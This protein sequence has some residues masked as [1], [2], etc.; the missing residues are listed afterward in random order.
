MIDT[1]LDATN[2]T[3]FHAITSTSHGY[4][5]Y[6]YTVDKTNATVSITCENHVSRLTYASEIKLQEN[7]TNITVTADS[8]EDSAVR[9]NED[10]VFQIFITEG[11]HAVVNVD[12]GDT[13]SETITTHDTLLSYESAIEIHHTYTESMAA[14]VKI[15]LRNY[16]FNVTTFLPYALLV[17]NLV[18]GLTIEC[19]AEVMIGES[20]EGTISI[21]VKPDVSLP[22]PTNVSCD[23][24][25]G[26]GN[27]VTE[28]STELSTRQDYV[29]PLTFVRDNVGLGNDVSVSC[30][31]LVSSQEL[32]ASIDVYEEVIG[33]NFVQ[34]PLYA[35]VNQPMSMQIFLQ[36]GSHVSYV[37]ALGNGESVTLT[38]NNTF[39]TDHPFV[40]FLTYDGIGNFTPIVEAR[41]EMSS[42]SGII[43]DHVTVQ[44]DIAHLNISVGS[45]YIW[46]PGSAE[47]IIT[48]SAA[49][50]EIHN[51]HCHLVY[52]NNKTSEHSSYQYIDSME[53]SDMFSFTYNMS[54]PLLGN[55]TVNATCGNMVSNITIQATTRVVLDAVILERLIT[56]DTVLW[57]NTTLMI[58]DIKRF[59][60]NACFQFDMGDGREHI[61]YGSSDFCESPAVDASESYQHIEPN[62]MQPYHEY[63][64]KRFGKYNVTVFA[65]NHVSTDTLTTEAEVL[66]WPCIPP[67]ISFPGNF[68]ELDN[69]MI[70]NKSV[71]FTINP[72]VVIDCMKTAKFTNL[73][74]LYVTGA[75]TPMVISGSDVRWVYRPEPYQQ[76]SRLLPYGSYSLV[77][78]ASM[79]NVTPEQISS[80]VTYIEIVP[81][82]LEAGFIEGNNGTHAYDTITQLDMKMASFDPDVEPDVKSGMTFIWLCRREHEDE[83]KADSNLIRMSFGMTNSDDKGG[84]FGTGSGRL[85]EPEDSGVL[86]INT[87][88]MLPDM[89]YVIQGI[90]YKD[91]REASTVHRIY[92]APSEAPILSLR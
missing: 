54:R 13:T 9:T 25:L 41:N 38:N 82:P 15:E 18:E 91:D 53:A 43:D 56:N 83:V 87:K 74:E 16:Y 86:S 69:P 24:N 3:V 84:C 85:E 63:I 50:T 2:T 88:Y 1:S 77:Y 42:I 29:K 31:N 75:P 71:S 48:A 7:F 55:T 40:A 22:I 34:P 14:I 32:D 58:L 61:L 11:S 92:I 73:W 52:Y 67:N 47:Y 6:Q 17:Q 21:S 19:P 70:I 35:L 78:T 89:N 66:D 39:A 20:G 59:G 57:T 23:W 64:Y 12:F 51:M 49:Q 46:P 81:T 90:V 30:F 8:N 36:Y 62:T 27:N 76:Q 28:F 80:S 65:Y 37:V 26:S 4:I 79:F 5:H 10:V 72:E 60:R 33:L 44:N 45:E 68:S